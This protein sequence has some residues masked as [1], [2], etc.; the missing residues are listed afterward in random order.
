MAKKSQLALHWAMQC[1]NDV[2]EGVVDAP[3]N[4]SEPTPLALFCLG[5]IGLGFAR[6]RA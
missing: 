5:L 1:G 2:I 6:R 3:I 4:V